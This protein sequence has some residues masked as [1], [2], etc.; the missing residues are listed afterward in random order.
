MANKILESSAD[1]KLG[2]INTENTSKETIYRVVK[3]VTTEKAKSEKEVKEKFHEETLIG[4][5]DAREIRENFE[6]T[7]PKVKIE[8]TEKKS[9]EKVEN[10]P[11]DSINQV[12]KAD[13]NQEQNKITPQDVHNFVADIILNDDAFIHDKNVS[14]PGERMR[15]TFIKHLGTFV[16]LLNEE[17]SLNTLDK[18]FKL[19]MGAEMR[20]MRKAINKGKTIN[21]GNAGKSNYTIDDVKNF[22]EKR[23]FE[24]EK[25]EK[26]Y[27]E[28]FSGM[29]KAFDETVKNTA[30]K[31]QDSLS[32]QLKSICGGGTNENPKILEKIKEQISNLKKL[33][34]KEAIKEF[35]GQSESLPNEVREFLEEVYNDFDKI[36]NSCTQ[37]KNSEYINDS[38][39]KLTDS[40]HDLLYARRARKED[41]T[42]ESLIKEGK[43]IFLDIK[44]CLL[45]DKLENALSYLEKMEKTLMVLKVKN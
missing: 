6:N 8:K 45:E 39:R 43:A 23:C 32:E 44:R 17:I 13:G 34:S 14:K 4:S 19:I 35:E 41:E 15:Q 38:L 40:M 18:Y 24:G 20:K 22:L 2:D 42:D 36:G 31:M 21:E 9:S 7:K 27:S 11:V 28:I 30:D 10:A 5:N 33:Y 3:R 1:T 26:E 16:A 37:S 25:G 12:N 29:E